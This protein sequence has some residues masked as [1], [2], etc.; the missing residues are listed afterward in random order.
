MLYCRM[1]RVLLLLTA[2]LLSTYVHMPAAAQ[3]TLRHEEGQDADHYE[4]GF[5]N[6][7]RYAES[8]ND[9]DRD[10]WQKPDVLLEAMGLDEGMTV[11]DLGTGT[12][13]FI[14]HLARAVGAEGRVLAVDIEP[15]M[16]DYVLEQTEKLGLSSVDTVH[17]VPNDTRLGASSVDRILTVNTWHHIPNRGNYAGH[18]ASRLKDDGSVWV[19]D[20][21]KEAPMGPPKKH[22][23]DPQDIVDEL[24]EGGFEAERRDLGL[25]HQHV[26]VGRLE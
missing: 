10:E 26:I 13:Y 23:L 7:E 5:E 14:P 17:A 11:A 15:A 9:P 25:P 24:E 21:T 1:P 16:L 19:I 18:L 22:R 4:H 6:P 20:F 3:D 8:W 2:V 12:G